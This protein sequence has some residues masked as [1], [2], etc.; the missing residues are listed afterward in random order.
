MKIMKKIVVLLC[1]FALFFVVISN[2]NSSFAITGDDVKTNF[3]GTTDFSSTDGADTKIT[4]ILG[5]V[6]IVIRIA[7]IGI[8][9]VMLT[10]IGAKYML[11]SP[12]ERADIKQHM[13]VY[14]VGAFV[15]FGAGMIVGIVEKFAATNISA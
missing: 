7:T 9:L 2:V 4:N 12:N 5:I 14:V 8:G 10:V 1:I 6:L 13:V 3:G 11:A 15:F